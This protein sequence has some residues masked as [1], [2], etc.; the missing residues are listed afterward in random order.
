MGKARNSTGWVLAGLLTVFMTMSAVAKI[1]GAATEQ[2]AAMGLGDQVLLIGIG[3][4]A[5]A[6]LFLIPLTLSAGALLQSAY[7][8]GAIVAHMVTNTPFTVPAIVLVLVWTIVL[9]RRPELYGPLL[10]QRSPGA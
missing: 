6:V 3:E 9:I 10:P 2:F 5:T 4:L 7:W 1:T 8:G